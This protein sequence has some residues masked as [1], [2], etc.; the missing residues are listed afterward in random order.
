MEYANKKTGFTGKVTY[1]PS[2]DDGPYV[3][4]EKEEYYNLINERNQY[5][6]WWETE[7]KAHKEEVETVRKIAEE[8][9]DSIKRTAQTDISAVQMDLDKQTRLNNNLLRIMKERSNAARGMQPKKKKSGYRFDGK[10]MQTK[11]ISGHD[12]KTGAIYTD[13]WVATLETPY[14]ATI[15]IKDIEE[16]IQMDLFRCE[17]SDRGILTR[18]GIGNLWYTDGGVWKGTYTELNAWKKENNGSGNYM[19]DFKYL[20]N[21]KTGLWEI[22]ITTTDPIP[23]IPDLM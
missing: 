22:Q 11:T 9:V 1:E 5:E 16:R 2:S 23:L 8:K 15:P 12:K 10:I 7:K 19:F 18:N 4:L 14:D 6:H 20:I 13:V 21:P 17:N 3:I